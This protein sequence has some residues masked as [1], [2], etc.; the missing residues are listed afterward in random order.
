MIGYADVVITANNPE[1]K[2][3]NTQEFIALGE[4]LLVPRIWELPFRLRNV[5]DPIGFRQLQR[6]CLSL[7]VGARSEIHVLD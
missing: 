7:A 2:N 3:V 1:T 6:S 4:N 5:G